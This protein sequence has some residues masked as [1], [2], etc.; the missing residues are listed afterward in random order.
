VVM[1][2]QAD[3]PRDSSVAGISA[4]IGRMEDELVELRGEKAALQAARRGLLLA[5]TTIDVERHDSRLRGLNVDIERIE[6]QTEALRS[7][8][9]TARGRERIAR[10]EAMRAE[11]ASQIEIAAQFWTQK[12]EGLAREIA[13]GVKLTQAAIESRAALNAAIEKANSTPG[14]VAAGGVPPAKLPKFP[15]DGRGEAWQRPTYSMITLPSVLGDGSPILWPSGYSLTHTS[16][17][18]RMRPSPFAI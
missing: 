5:G 9:A 12:Y 1:T 7:D 13:D 18:R 6:A 10:I 8:L 16:E 14:V 17:L 11:V 3:R 4:S 15:W 2:K